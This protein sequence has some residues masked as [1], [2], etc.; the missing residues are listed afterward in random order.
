VRARR[1]WR[2]SD[3]ALKHGNGK[4]TRGLSGV[5]MKQGAIAAFPWAANSADTSKPDI[6]G[7]SKIDANDPAV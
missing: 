2:D 5:K 7:G 1:R 3:A 4:V 6:S